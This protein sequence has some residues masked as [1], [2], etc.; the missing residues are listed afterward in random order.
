MIMAVMR[1]A[2]EVGD[3]AMIAVCKRALNDEM[4]GKMSRSDRDTIYTFY[5][6]L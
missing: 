6:D 4:R 3:P 5:K 2:R 1:R